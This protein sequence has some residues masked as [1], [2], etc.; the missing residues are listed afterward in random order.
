MNYKV[1]NTCFILF[2][3]SLIIIAGAFTYKT[4]YF[5]PQN[6]WKIVSDEKNHVYVAKNRGEDICYLYTNTSNMIAEKWVNTHCDN[7]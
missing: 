2:A 4:F 6:E 5:D 7:N 1:I 3:I